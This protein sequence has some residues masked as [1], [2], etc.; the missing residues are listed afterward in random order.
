MLGNL[1]TSKKYPENLNNQTPPVVNQ[2]PVVS[3]PV[4]QNVMQSQTADE[5]IGSSMKPVVR[6]DLSILS[7]LDTRTSALLN[8]AEHEAK[9]IKQGLIEPE[10]LLIGLTFDGEIFQLLVKF[11]VDVPAL[12]RELQA[13]EQLGT[14]AENPT[15][16]D[17]S[18]QIFEKAY[19]MVKERGIEFISPEDLLI[20]IF[21][22]NAAVATFLQS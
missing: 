14:F 12:S 6:A 2:T 21:E 7:H 17:R 10:Q 16:S 22:K 3:L 5:I 4:D 15:L 20:A 1:F 13:K 18:K 9:R 8:Q 11:S 19:S